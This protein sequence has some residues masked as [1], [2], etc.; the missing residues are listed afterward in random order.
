MGVECG[1]FRVS[2]REFLSCLDEINECYESVRL[3]VID[4]KKVPTRFEYY[5]LLEQFLDFPWSFEGMFDRYN[6]F[7]RYLGDQGC[8]VIVLAIKNSQYFLKGN[9]R[10]RDDI[11][12]TFVNDTFVCLKEHG[13]VSFF[14]YLF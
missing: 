2:E 4:G 7:L 10:D 6:D 1:I 13:D 8:D 14:I 5:V 9:M 11:F 12:D 3:M